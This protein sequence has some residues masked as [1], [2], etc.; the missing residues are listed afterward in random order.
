MY[1]YIYICIYTYMYVYAVYLVTREPSGQSRS[2]LFRVY[3]VCSFP[4]YTYM[5]IRDEHQGESLV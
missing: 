2:S 1:I 3:A 4:L 5:G